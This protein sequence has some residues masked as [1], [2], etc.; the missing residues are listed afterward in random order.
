MKPV[1]LLLTLVVFLCSSKISAQVFYRVAEDT[2]PVRMVYTYTNPLDLMFERDNVTGILRLPDNTFNN[3]S[4][5]GLTFRDTLFYNPLFLPVIFDGNVLPRNLSFYPVRDERS[6][7]TLISQNRTFASRLADIDFAQNVRQQFYIE[8][9]TQIRYSVLNLPNIRSANDDELRP[10]NPFRELIRAESSVEL[11]TPTVEGATI[12]RRY[13]QRSG[14]HSLQFSQNYFSENW[15][16]GGINSTNI[17]SFQT[18]RANYRKEKVRFDNTVEWRLALNSTSTTDT[19]RDYTI[20]NDLIRY[21]GNFGID[22][23][24]KG[25]SYSMNVEARTQAFNG[26]PANSAELRSAF[27]SPLYVN[28]GI[29]LTYKLDKRSEK[30]R[31]RRTRLDLALAPASINFT[32]V[33]HPDVDV[34]RFGIEEGKMH[35]LDL[36]STVNFNMIY[37]MTR[38][39]TWTSKFTYF[40]SYEKVISE[41]ENTLNMSLTNALSTRIQVNMRYDDGVP[42]HDK[43]GNRYPFGLLQVNQMLSFGLN[44]KW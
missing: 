3:E 5:R 31:H 12:G 28:A 36:G 27:L 43:D 32:Y 1:F 8:N 17:N 44:Y 34:R 29:G 21:S 14:E 40:T 2:I 30:V 42:S 18:I 41:F 10:F 16:R 26:Y 37:D 39:I 24:G 23:F 13:W 6:R 4:M 15:H 38:F 19:L 22:A 25:W 9:P 11:I 33:N 7:G 35:N 20:S